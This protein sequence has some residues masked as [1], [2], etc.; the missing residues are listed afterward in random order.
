VT[1]STAA[2]PASGDEGPHHLGHRERLRRR[3]LAGGSEGLPDYEVLE[4]LLFRAIPRRDVKPLAKELIRRFGSLADVVSA[5]V[6]AL[7]AVPGLGEAAAVE[8]KIVQAAALR[9]VR[10]E[11][12]AR[13]VIESWA[14]LI[15]Y[16]QA[17]MAYDDT[18]HVRVLFLN[19]KNRVIADEVQSRGTIDQAPVYPREVVRRALAL[20][21]SALILVHNHPSGDPTPSR[22]DVA[23][24]QQIAEAAAVFDITLHDHVVIGRGRHVSFKA[25]GLI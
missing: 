4:L 1:D 22:A 10:A 25:L 20:S 24:T 14:A 5:P 23:M 9:L 13:P 18:E 7:R 8:L 16:C 19:R 17:V 15:A 21:A 6:E 2:G 3:F 12:V 11:A